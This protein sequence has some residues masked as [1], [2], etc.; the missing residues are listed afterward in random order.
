MSASASAWSPLAREWSLI[1]GGLGLRIVAP[2]AIDLPTGRVDA[3]VLLVD[4][5]ASNGMLLV[6]DVERVWPH[7]DSTVE[8]GFGF[9]VLSAPEPT[10]PSPADWEPIKEMLREWG[11]AGRVDGEPAWMRVANKQGGDSAP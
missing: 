2:F 4:F 1:A 5:G 11:W 8:A 9:S 6:T 3:D 7:R 10:G